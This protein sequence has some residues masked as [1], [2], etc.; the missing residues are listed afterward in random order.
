MSCQPE[1]NPRPEASQP[2]TDPVE[3]LRRWERFGAS[4]Q[5][6]ARTG[7]GVTVALCRCDG[8]EEVQRLTSDNPN[9]LAF[10]GNRTSSED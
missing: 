3:L 4:W 7:A 1:A 6:L 9:L 10:L 5:V 8:G 2:E